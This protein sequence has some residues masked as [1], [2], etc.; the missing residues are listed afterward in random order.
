MAVYYGRHHKEMEEETY[1]YALTGHMDATNDPRVRKYFA[2]VC[3]PYYDVD[4]IKRS[5]QLPDDKHFYKK[6]EIFRNIPFSLKDRQLQADIG[7]LLFDVDIYYG[8]V[9]VGI[10]DAIRE[11]INKDF[12]KEIQEQLNSFAFANMVLWRTRNQ[13][14]DGIEADHE[15]FIN[16]LTEKKIDWKDFYKFRDYNHLFSKYYVPSKKDYFNNL[17][18]KIGEYVVWDRFSKMKN[19]TFV[20][21]DINDSF[22]YDIYFELDG[23]ET[24]VEVKTTTSICGNDIVRLTDHEIE[25]YKEAIKHGAKY[26]IARVYIPENEPYNFFYSFLQYD[27]DNDMLYDNIRHIEYERDTNVRKRI[28]RNNKIEYLGHRKGFTMMSM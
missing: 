22:G 6:Q 12:T 21:R 10:S 1:F 27:E 4:A 8:Y 16:Y 2:E 26:I 28:Y 24:L 18:G 13:E 15:R 3:A 19:A 11:F 25:T 5:L 23:I 7:T 17:V 9:S 14:S 20:S